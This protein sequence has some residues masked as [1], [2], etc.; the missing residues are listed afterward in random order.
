M[1]FL[2]GIFLLS[3]TCTFAG[4]NGGFVFFS[5]DGFKFHVIMNG[6]LYNK[7]AQTNVEI[8]NLSGGVY[9]IMIV[10]ESKTLKGRKTFHMNSFQ[11]ITWEVVR[12]GKKKLAINLAGA[13]FSPRKKKRKNRNRLRVHWGF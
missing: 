1:K 3:V 8:K 7:E 10:D 5:N 2:F 12:K 11:T 6:E 13:K 9:K 4:D